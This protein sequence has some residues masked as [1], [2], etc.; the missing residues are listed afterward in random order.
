MLKRLILVV[1]RLYQLTL[2]PLFGPC[3]R[4]EP[5]CSRYAATCVDRF[6]PARGVWL[7]L[8]RLARCHPWGGHG[9]DS[10]PQLAG[11]SEGILK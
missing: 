11:R 3:C 1:I 7:A 6:G 4:F 2:A 9:F 5:S 10:P 8:K